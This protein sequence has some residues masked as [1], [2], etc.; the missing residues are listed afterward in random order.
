MLLW[1][2]VT[3]CLS[4][5]GALIQYF[6]GYFVIHIFTM[7][8]TDVTCFSLILVLGLTAAGGLPQNTAS[9]PQ[10]SNASADV[11]SDAMKRAYDALGLRYNKPA[12]TTTPQISH[13]QVPSGMQPGKLSIFYVIPNLTV[14]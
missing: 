4:V 10:T 8:F 12:T 2:L 5:V 11:T 3:L 9:L 6:L 14:K 7:C 13:P 1:G